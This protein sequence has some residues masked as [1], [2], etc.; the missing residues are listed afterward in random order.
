MPEPLIEINGISKSFKGPEGILPTLRDIN[1]SIEKGSFVSII[2]PSGC[3]KST[4]FNIICGLITPDTGSVVIEGKNVTGQRGVVS[5]MPQKDLLFPW[6]TIIDNVVIGSLIE[7]RPV[8][9][10]K[11]R[12]RELFGVFG[13]EGF[14]NSYPATLSGGMRQRAALMRTV[15]CEKPI[16]LLDESFGGLDAMTRRN[17][18]AWL[19]NI[20]ERFQRSVLFITH[21]IEE[22]LYLSDKVYVLT[23]RPAE[24]GLELVVDLPRPRVVT[25]P[26]FVEYKKKLLAALE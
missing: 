10:S 17:M 7:G 23:E 13:L 8:E 9:E 18:Q 20:W 26:E 19:L 15:L 4:L 12:A 1:M 24:V 21:D 2:G 3:G 22:A 5:Y 14:E 11:K 16:M 25:S 6:R